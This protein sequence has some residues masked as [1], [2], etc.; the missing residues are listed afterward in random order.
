MKGQ[1]QKS[2]LIWEPRIKASTTDVEAIEKAIAYYQAA[3]AGFERNDPL[4]WAG[5]QHN[6]GSAYLHLLGYPSDNAATALQK[7]LT[8]ALTIRTRELPDE[9]RATQVLIGNLHFVARRWADAS[10]AYQ[11]AIQ[12]DEKIAAGSDSLDF[13]LSEGDGRGSTYSDAAYSL[14]RLER[15]GEAFLTMEKGRARV[16]ARGFKDGAT[17]S[18]DSKDS[19]DSADRSNSECEISPSQLLQ[20]DFMTL[21]SLA[22]RE[23]QTPEYQKLREQIRAELPSVRAQAGKARARLAIADPTVMLSNL[24][25]AI[26]ENAVLVAP[27]VTEVGSAVFVIRGGATSIGAEDIVWIDNFGNKELLRILN[28]DGAHTSVSG[29]LAAYAESTKRPKNWAQVISKSCDKLSKQFFGPIQVHLDALELP[30]QPHLIFL[31]AAGLSVLPVHACACQNKDGE[32]M[33]VEE[34]YTISYCPSAA[35]LANIHRRSRL[36]HQSFDTSMLV[37][38]NPTGDLPFAMLEGELLTALGRHVETL[39]LTGPDATWTAVAK[40]SQHR[41][42]LHFA[43]HGRYRS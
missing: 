14:L 35:L 3:A 28:G 20:V 5:S 29:W 31:L 33:Y 19:K 12:A 43:C 27:L 10:S 9:H 18:T 30:P 11:A 34:R 25:S 4:N 39:L 37:V 1:S 16:L 41:T 21:Y 17:D 40:N 13:Q 42:Y 2:S 26:P 22:E 24:L 15:F 7:C 8:N 6:L 23:A 36:L 38:A 32:K